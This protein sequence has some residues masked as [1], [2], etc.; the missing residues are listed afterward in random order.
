MNEKL[1]REAEYS[2]VDCITY[3]PFGYFKK[4]NRFYNHSGVL[5]ENLSQMTGLNIE[6]NLISQRWF[7]VPQAILPENLRRKR[8]PMF[9]RGKHSIEAKK[10][11]L[12]DDVVTTGRTL[13]D[14]VYALKKHNKIE[15]VVSLTFAC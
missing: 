10:V 7:C 14:A 2:D 12:I 5:A 11:L 8:P 3:I 6:H 13:S 15:R 1:L 9:G 4:H